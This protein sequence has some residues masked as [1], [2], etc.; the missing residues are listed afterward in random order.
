MVG[1]LP[2]RGVDMPPSTEVDGVREEVPWTLGEPPF[3]DEGSDDGEGG[4]EDW[5]TD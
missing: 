1:G 5:E 3:R 2:V 4:E